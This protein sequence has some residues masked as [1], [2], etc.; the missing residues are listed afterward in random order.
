MSLVR[1]VSIMKCNRNLIFAAALAFIGC[2]TTNHGNIHFTSPVGLPEYHH[3]DSVTLEFAGNA[4]QDFYVR[5][6]NPDGS[7]YHQSVEPLTI[8]EQ[9]TAQCTVTLE[10]DPGDIMILTGHFIGW[11]ANGGPVLDNVTSKTVIW[12]D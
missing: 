4:G 3:G 5:V 1:K 12:L 10:G 6:H 9:G 7:I 2:T 8:N 11:D